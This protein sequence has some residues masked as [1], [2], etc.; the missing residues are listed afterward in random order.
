MSYIWINNRRYYHFDDYNSKEEA[1][2]VAIQLKKMYR[3]KTFIRREQGGLFIP[4][5]RYCV[6]TSKPL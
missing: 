1:K 4:E 5:T 6:Y 2:G 3:T